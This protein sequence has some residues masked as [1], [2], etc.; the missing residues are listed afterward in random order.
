MYYIYLQS[1]YKQPSTDDTKI[2]IKQCTEYIYI[3][4][5]NCII[6]ETLWVTLY[7]KLHTVID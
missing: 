2:D 1:I 4:L 3:I 6:N 7:L 5:G